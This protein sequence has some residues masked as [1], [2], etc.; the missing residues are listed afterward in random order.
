MNRPWRHGYGHID[1][2]NMKPERWRELERTKTWDDTLRWGGAQQY[3]FTLRPPPAPFPLVPGFTYYTSPLLAQV[4][5]T[6]PRT[7]SVL[8]QITFDESSG[9]TTSAGSIFTFTFNLI[10][11]V[12]QAAIPMVQ[13]WVGDPVGGIIPPGQTTP[14]ATFAPLLAIFPPVA[15]SHINANVVIQGGK[16]SAVPIPPFTGSCSALL[17]PY[18]PEAG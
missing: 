16:V 18:F 4:Q 13:K 9:W 1:G 7:W 15:A 11:G 8:M 10:C 12:G 14:L 17:A 3:N 2:G 5:R 6:K